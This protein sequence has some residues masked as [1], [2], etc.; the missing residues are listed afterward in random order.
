M[1]DII[2]FL[3]KPDVMIALTPILIAGILICI[4]MLKEF[5]KWLVLI[6]I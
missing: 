4:Y 2:E 5:Y 6:M 1:K 3:L